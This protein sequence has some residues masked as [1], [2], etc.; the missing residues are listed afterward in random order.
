ML[1]GETANGI[2]PEQ[3]VK[4]MATICQNA[5]LGVNHNQCYNFIRSYTPKPVGSVEAV[6]AALVK[7]A[8][9]IRPGMMIVFSETGKMARYVAKYRPCVPVLVV[10]SNKQLARSVSALYACYCMLLDQHMAT[11]ADIKTTIKLSHQYGVQQG[12]CV[13]GKVCPQAPVM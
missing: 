1:S 9:D 11:S 4:V 3:A 2:D 6:V 5:E 8:F 7:N 12:L 10:T 13:P